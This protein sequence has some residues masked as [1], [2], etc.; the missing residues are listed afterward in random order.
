M[1]E[2]DAQSWVVLAVGLVSATAAAF[3]AIR[4]G[5]AEVRKTEVTGGYTFAA[6]QQRFVFDG[7]KLR[8]ESLVSEN[9][10]L[11]QKLRE[12]EED[13]DRCRER[14]RAT[15]PGY[16]SGALSLR[17]G[18]LAGARL[19]VVEDER[20]LREFLAIALR[21]AGAQVETADTAEAGRLALERAR[22]D[23]ILCDLQLPDAH[24]L[25][26]P[27][28]LR[29]QE[30]LSRGANDV[31]TPLLAFTAEF[32]GTEAQLRDAG[33]DGVLYKPLDNA[34]VLIER[35]RDLIRTARA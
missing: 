29:Q 8:I 17:R 7:L 23:A 15:W 20:P 18:P 2:S 27:R 34:D 31:R 24:D 3:A 9:Q 4:A 25:A 30:R 14:L 1:P 32:E 26:A 10:G 13:C 22:Y 11:R 28:R 21:E 16:E 6:E 12:C 5:R 19:L 35:L 33:G